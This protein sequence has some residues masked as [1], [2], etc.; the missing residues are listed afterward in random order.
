[1]ELK[2]LEFRKRFLEPYIEPVHVSRLE[3]GSVYYSVLYSEDDKAMAEPLVETVIFLGLNLENDE[4]ENFYFQDYNSYHDGIRIDDESNCYRGSI[5][6]GPKD[7]QVTISHIF[8]FEKALEELM[9][10]SLRREGQQ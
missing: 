4:E 9:R 8:E 5:Y 7:K 1:M 6:F 2:K 3:I 10:C